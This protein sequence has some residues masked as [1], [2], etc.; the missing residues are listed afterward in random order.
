VPVG[1]EEVAEGEE[2]EGGAEEGLGG[3]PA[4]YAAAFVFLAED[5]GAADGA[6]VFFED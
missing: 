3:S 1:D 2:L 6:G 5:E 4:V